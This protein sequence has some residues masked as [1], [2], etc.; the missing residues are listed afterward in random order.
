ML[1]LALLAIIAPLVFLVIFR[2][3]ARIGMSASALIVAAAAWLSW[4]MTPLAM[5][6]SVAQGVHRSLTIGLI[7]FGAL[8]LVK[9]MQSTGAMDR[10]KLGLHS[11]SPDMRVQTVVVAFAFIALLEGISG[12]GTPAIIAAPLLMVLGFRPIAAASLALLGDTMACTFGAAATPLIVGLENVPAYSD[13]LVS[14]VGA[15]VTLIDLIISPLLSLGLVAVLIFSFGYQSPRQKLKSL[16]E[17]APWAIFIG[18]VYAASAVVIVRL[19]GPELTSIMAGAISLGVA[20]LTA[21]NSW[22]T[23]KTIWRHHANPDET[24]E[25]IDSRTAEMPILKAWM[26]YV[27]VVV[28][29]LLSRLID[30]L[31]QWLSSTLDASWHNI[32][33]LESVSSTW[34]ILYSPGLILLVGVIIAVL[35]SQKQ[36]KSFKKPLVEALSSTTL[37]LSALIPTLIMVQLFTNSGINTS[38]LSAMPIFIAETLAENFQSLWLAIAP[39]LGAIGA[40]ISGSATVS[41]LTMAPMQYDIALDTELPFVTVLA[42][43]MIGAA[44]GNAM[45]IH[46]VVAA[47]VVVGLVHRENIIMRKLIVPTIIY[48]SV[49]AL[50]GLGIFLYLR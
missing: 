12:F 49:T 45:A 4:G 32:F 29:L 46:N 6:A 8:L 24:E 39:L 20:S 26:P 50:I 28:L 47:S 13:N 23:P 44:A 19:I 27:V 38:G 35:I 22:L 30:P 17:I 34:N 15:Q 16:A 14:V 36:L 25:V 1:L 31:K 10:I 42:L 2:L 9:T 43:Q 48:I 21:K 3:P 5:A 33:G 7:L 18:L 40:F 11:I 37:A 41:N